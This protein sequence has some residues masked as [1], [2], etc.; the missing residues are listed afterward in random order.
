[1]AKLSAPGNP[2]LTSR[3]RDKNV[4]IA[5]LALAA[6]LAHVILRYGVRLDGLTN[7]S[8]HDLPLVLALL[9]GGIP[10]I[11]AL[12]RQAIHGDFGSD[13]L[14]GI[15]IVTA[16]ALGEYLAGTIVVLMLSGGQ[17]LENYAL[18]RASSVL[19]A[20]AKRMPSIA[21]RR[22]RD[23]LE[24]KPLAEISIGDIV[25]IF[26]HEI[27]PV[28]GLVVDGHGVMD[29]SYL[30]GEPYLISKAPGSVVLSGAINGENALGV[31]TTARAVD[32]RYSKI[33]EVMRDTEQRRPKLRRMADQLGAYYTPIALAM[34]VA[35]W[36]VSG[37]AIRFL[38]VLVV[39]TPC[40]LLIAIP[41]AIIGSI[42]LAAR[43]G[44]IVKDP[45]VL[46]RLDTCRVAIFDKTGTLTY[47]KPELVEILPT[48]AYPADRVLA[49]VASVERY[50]KHPLANAIVSEADR[51]G[52]ATLEVSDVSEPPGKGLRANVQGTTVQVTGRRIAEELGADLPPFTGGM[53][54]TILIDGAYAALLKFRDRPR[55]E[56]GRFISHLAPR[57]RI[58]K[59]LLVSGDRE[60]EVRHLAEHVGIEEVYFS[61]SPE[62]KV[63]LVRQQ[64]EPTLFLG[65]GIND[66]PALAEA[67]VGIAFGQNSDITSEAAGAVVMDS[68]LGRVDELMH[69]GRWM[70]SIALQSA[71]GGMALSI[72]FMIYALFG[73]LP[74]V[75]GA[76]VQEG[77]DIFAVV[78][79]LR[80]ARAPASLTDY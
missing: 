6:I 8:A 15:S 24:D 42:S 59:L 10:L 39:A 3:L 63:A 37:D 12:I 74:P 45:S 14:A 46:E 54:C 41:V 19:D 44:I 21:H 61:Q 2:S 40:P 70:R 55:T 79:A 43:R 47:G 73:Y 80:A 5:M 64:E 77:I 29:E 68:A 50:S 71:V 23:A 30:T 51:R 36:L 4:A 53:E 34:G 67:T 78:N 60:S 76:L 25:V 22:R 17:A 13:L 69:I 18:R 32:S 72:V 20:L 16:V 65:D 48:P 26:P 28:D 52:L 9:V 7:L 33:M 49:L 56:S 66:A 62:Q 27:C 58:K 38:A 57:H 75:A 31:R 35:G 11:I 1:M